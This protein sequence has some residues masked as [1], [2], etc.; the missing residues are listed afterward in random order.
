MLNYIHILLSFTLTMIGIQQTRVYRVRSHSMRQSYQRHSLAEICLNQPQLMLIGDRYLAYDDFIDLLQ[1]AA[2]IN[3]AVEIL[4]TLM[5]TPYNDVT[6]F[7]VGA[8]QEFVRTVIT[9]DGTT[10]QYHRLYREYKKLNKARTQLFQSGRIVLHSSTAHITLQQGEMY[11]LYGQH[12]H[13][14]CIT[15]MGDQYDHRTI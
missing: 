3:D 6:H 13:Q 5:L 8:T 15:S 1:P 14:T 4:L 12:Q 9:S 10:R 2:L 7:S 11:Q